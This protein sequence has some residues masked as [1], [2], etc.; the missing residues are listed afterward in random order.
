MNLESYI[1]SLDVMLIYTSKWILYC[2][3]KG[4]VAVIRIILVVVHVMHVN[5]PVFKFMNVPLA[6]R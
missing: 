1:N 3:V 2:Q 5:K 6:I 4:V